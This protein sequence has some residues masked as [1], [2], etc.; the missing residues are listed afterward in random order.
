MSAMLYMHTAEPLKMLLWRKRK[1]K[2]VRGMER[3]EFKDE[4]EERARGRGMKKDDR[5]QQ[6]GFINNWSRDR[7]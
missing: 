4:D 7:D 3:K 6:K 5:Q 2:G 1:R